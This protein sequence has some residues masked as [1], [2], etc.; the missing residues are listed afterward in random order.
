[1][2]N[3]Y[4]EVLGIDVPTL[5]S[6]EGHKEASTW[7]RFLVTL[8]AEG[9]PLTLEQAAERFAAAG[10]GMRAEALGALKRCEP[11]RIPVYRHGERYFLDRHDREA[12]MWA[13]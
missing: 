4:C 13:V 12:D 3:P 6:I 1:V 2:S 8:I 9:G 11:G 10:L 5:A 7:A